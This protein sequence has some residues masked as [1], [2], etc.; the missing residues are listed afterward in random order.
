[1]QERRCELEAFLKLVQSLDSGAGSDAASFKTLTL[2]RRIPHATADYLCSLFAKPAADIGAAKAPEANRAPVNAAA[3]APRAAAPRDAAEVDL[4]DKGS[5]QWAA[6]V[7]KPG[8]AV[9]LQLLA[10]LVKG[11]QV[12]GGPPPVAS[13][14]H[15]PQLSST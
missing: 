4:C 7:A 14:Y 15:K 12:C 2:A 3:E 9:A 6:G 8:V 10:A 1:M 5:K 13:M 11:H